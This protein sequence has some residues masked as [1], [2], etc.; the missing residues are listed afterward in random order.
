MCSHY[1]WFAINMIE[2]P[3]RGYLPPSRHDYCRCFFLPPA[4]KFQEVTISS[5]WAKTGSKQAANL[6]HFILLNLLSTINT[7]SIALSMC[8][9]TLTMKG[10]VPPNIIRH[11]CILGLAD[12]AIRTR[13]NPRLSKVCF[14]SLLKHGKCSHRT[15]K[16]RT[17][18]ML[19]A[20]GQ[21]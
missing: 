5:S 12:K 9:T 20:D 19:R 3:K 6:S 1:L 14:H 8:Y 18:T 7:D 4:R 16:Q 10:F 17:P 21:V 13:K 2:T 11:I 15:V